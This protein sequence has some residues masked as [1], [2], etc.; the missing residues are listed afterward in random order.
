[1][2]RQRGRTGAKSNAS[3][4]AV[5]RLQSGIAHFQA[6]R[7]ADAEACFRQVLEKFPTYPDA[8][9]LLGYVALAT[10]RHAAGIDLISQ[11]IRHNGDNPEYHAHLGAG[12]SDVGRL[13]EALASYTAALKLR[14]NFPAALRSRADVL[15][16]LNRLEE[17][18]ADYERAFSLK[19]DYVDAVSAAGMILRRLGRHAEAETKFLHALRL[20]PQH[21]PTLILRGAMMR[22]LKRFDEAVSD[23]TAAIVLKRDVPEALHERGLMFLAI[24][25][26]A[27]AVL[28]L[29]SAV[30]LKP[31][32][33]EAYSDLGCA[34][35]KTL[36]LEMAVENFRKAIQIDPRHAG[37]LNNLGFALVG[38]NRPQ[39]ALGLLDQAIVISPGT[40]EFLNTKGV[41]LSAL[42]RF[43]E[44]L[45]YFDRAITADPGNAE[46][47]LNIAINRLRLGDLKRGWTEYEWRWKCSSQNLADRRFDKP[48]W[49]G[50]EPIAGKV[51]LL[52]NDQ[53]LGDALQF[54]RYVTQLRNLGAELILEIDGPLRELL[55]KLPGISLCIAKGA[56]LPHFDFHCPLSSLPLAFSTTLDTIPSQVP[57][58]PQ[59]SGETARSLG[60][61]RLP[62]IGLVWSGNASH[63]NDH[64]RSIPFNQLLPLLGGVEAQFVSLQKNTRSEDEHLL[65]QRSDV[66]DLGP[67][68]RDFS[69]TAA[70]VA[71][72]DLVISVDTSVAHLAGGLGRPLWILLPFIP[73]WRWLLDRDDSPWYPTARLFRQ[74]AN[75]GW[76]PVVEQVRDAL[77][78]RIA[79]AA[80]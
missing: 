75:S 66:L 11:A 56:R 51:V 59:L 21:L 49:L 3:D 79:R 78:D 29:E 4:L 41:A 43:D 61:G 2:N 37:A 30:A 53:G 67:E 28:D 23:L 14:S 22:D 63:T 74:S 50:A 27:E 26:F 57:Y 8:L 34:L 40:S 58:L 19:P 18:L 45:G 48:L 77:I 72:L 52:H 39:E 73:D 60:S 64:N 69:D 17:A 9:H 32:F 20:D 47:H 16:R 62:R 25:R 46:A 10:Q 54:C 36:R 24:G 42:G 68:L 38:L 12:Y 7:T 70:I 1:M 15:A 44:A 5:A 35:A 80:Q 13:S 33:A 65:R 55:S 31:D 6:G 76:A 71:Q